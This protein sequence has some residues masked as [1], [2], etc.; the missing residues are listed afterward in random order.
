MDTTTLGAVV[1]P[2]LIASASTTIRLSADLKR[3]GTVF[4]NTALEIECCRRCDPVR[5]VPC[6]A[7]PNADI[8]QAEDRY[9]SCVQRAWRRAVERTVSKPTLEA[10]LSSLE[11]AGFADK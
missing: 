10:I 5:C 1:L 7:S 11:D 2:G 9:K 6:R 3:C 4:R 8:F